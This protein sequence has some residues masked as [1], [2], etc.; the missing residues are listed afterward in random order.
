MISHNYIYNDIIHLYFI[1]YGMFIIIYH[2]IFYI[3][4][5]VIPIKVDNIHI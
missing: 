3:K 4:Y 1:I 5:I 2:N